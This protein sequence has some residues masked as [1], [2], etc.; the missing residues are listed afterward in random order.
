MFDFLRPNMNS[1]Q[2]VSWITDCQNF[3]RSDISDVLSCLNIKI[4]DNVNESPYIN[5]VV[6]DVLTKLKDKKEIFADSY[7]ICVD[8]I[9]SDIDKEHFSWLDFAR[10]I[11]SSNHKAKIVLLGFVSRE[12][13]RKQKGKIFDWIVSH[14]NVEFVD[15][16]NM[17][18]QF[19]SFNFSGVVDKNIYLYT[20]NELAKQF[21]SKTR[22]Y[23]K[24]I[25]H[26][27]YPKNS[28]EKKLIN[29][30]FEEMRLYFP[31]L[32]T[33][34]KMLDFVFCTNMD[35]PEKMLGKKVDWV[36][37]EFDWAL[38]DYVWQHSWQVWAQELRPSVIKLLREQE[39]MGKQIFIMATGN[40]HRK[41]EFIRYLGIDWPV[42]DRSQYAWV[43]AEVV[44]G[45]AD[46]NAFVAQSKIYPETFVDTTELE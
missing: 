44:V 1:N 36:Y 16:S 38:I 25:K 12:E 8:D 24:D 45:N 5:K 9:P 39:S 30:V 27:H 35:I 31:G 42:I 10:N 3:S 26:P 21:I 20:T 43:T 41:E 18:T 14:P 22:D 6:N 19:S 28:F 7:L 15:V 4:V 40:V 32:N 2:T 29:E 34:E 46:Q 33:V 23:L 37:C 11:L 17:D 13:V